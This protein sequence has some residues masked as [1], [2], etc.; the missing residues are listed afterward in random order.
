MWMS[1]EVL[2]LAPVEPG[3]DYNPGKQVAY[4]LGPWARTQL[5][6]STLRDDEGLLF[7]ADKF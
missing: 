3:Y 7:L 1:L 4:S 6:F 2:P 5:R